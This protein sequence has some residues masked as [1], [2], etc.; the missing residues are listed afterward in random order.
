[1]IFYNLN[2]PF[3]RQQL[4]NIYNYGYNGYNWFIQGVKNMNWLKNLMRGRYG[5]DQLSIA[6]LVFSIVIDII[7]S[8][9]RLPVLVYV[10]YIP[11][12][13]CFYRMFS[14]DINRRSMENYKFYSLMNPVYSWFRNKKQWLSQTKT[15]RFFKCPGCKATL[16]IPKGKGKIV[17]TCPKC[18]KEFGKK[19]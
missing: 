3:A 18:K 2:L 7:G 5:G 8:L 6:L 12:F 11:L 1:M 17:I 16:R 15:Y 19:T 10:G 9:A 13:L 4:P 14:R